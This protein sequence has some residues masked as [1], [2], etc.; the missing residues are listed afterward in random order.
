MALGC[1]LTASGHLLTALRSCLSTASFFLQLFL[2]ISSGKQRQAWAGGEGQP[3][4]LFIINKCVFWCPL[5]HSQ[6]GHAAPDEGGGRIKAAT[7]PWPGRVPQA[8]GL[9]QHKGMRRSECA[10]VWQAMPASL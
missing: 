6:H 5:A 1:L 9:A 4:F 10:F 8:G 7:G 2:E 3:G